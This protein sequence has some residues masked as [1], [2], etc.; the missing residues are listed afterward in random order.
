MRRIVR[1]GLAVTLL[2]G[3]A[4]PARAHHRNEDRDVPCERIH[5]QEVEDVREAVRR[6]IRCAERLWPVPGGL[7][8]ALAV[9]RCESGFWPW[10]RGGPNAGVYQ[11]NLAYWPPRWERWGRPLG[12]GSSAFNARTNVVVTMRM[13]HSSRSWALWACA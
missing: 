12:L 4:A 3:G 5:W 9:A 1:V 2:A 13:V 6:L 10:A 7:E 11:H 8:K